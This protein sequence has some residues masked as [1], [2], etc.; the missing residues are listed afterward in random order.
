M[1]IL[2]IDGLRLRRPRTAMGRYIE[3]MVEHWSSTR[4]AFDRIALYVPSNVQDVEVPRGSVTEVI[5]HRA[6]PM[7]LI[8]WEQLWLP[9]AARKASVLF[10][11]AYVAPVVRHSPLVVAN[12]GIYE[13][14][15]SEFS[16]VRR[17]RTVPLFRSSARRA[18]RVVANSDVTRDDLLRFFGVRPEKVEVI[19]PAASELFFR[20]D[21]RAANA[22]LEELFGQRVPYILFVGKLSPRRH[23]PELIAAL[24]LARRRA[25]FAH[26]LLIVGPNVEGLDI[27]RLTRENGM[28][29]V[30]VHVPSLEQP[31]LAALY[32]ACDLFVL[33]TT[34]EGS[35]WT[36]LEA[37]ASGAPVLT[38]QHPQLRE[39][40]GDAVEVVP[41]PDPE[42]LAAAMVRLLTDAGARDDLSSRGRRQARQFSWKSNAEAT[43][44]VL[45]KVAF[46]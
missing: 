45:E 12:H 30:V 2:A 25:G 7:P 37:M 22:V 18:D 34:Y 39:T 44:R 19:R 6:P 26:R 1:K 10:C 27:A 33:P 41:Q 4:S 21:E 5:I 43:L 29:G 14:L 28:E 13:A 8:V 36:I 38:V 20:A 24:G 15:P 17:M 42:Q 35:S 40:A 31:V 9:I 11:P 23:V 32:A 46:G 16:V 3:L